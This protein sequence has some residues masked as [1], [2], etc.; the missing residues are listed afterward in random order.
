MGCA[1]FPPYKTKRNNCFNHLELRLK[2]FLTFGFHF[3]Q[4]LDGAK[5]QGIKNNFL[6]VSLHKLAANLENLEEP[7]L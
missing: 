4:C 1:L 7:S 2:T 5:D 3:S 6:M